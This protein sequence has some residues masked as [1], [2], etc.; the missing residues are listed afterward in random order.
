[1]AS[2]VTGH[3]R[4]LEKNIKYEWALCARVGAYQWD[5]L[6]G[7]QPQRAHMPR[8]FTIFFRNKPRYF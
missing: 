3:N 2:V 4:M 1:M 7:M 6:A 8:V 5:K